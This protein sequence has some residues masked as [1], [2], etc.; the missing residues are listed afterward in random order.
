MLAGKTPKSPTTFSE[1]YTASD[2]FGDDAVRHTVRAGNKVVGHMLTSPEGDEMAV[3]NVEVRA[4][5]QGKGY[6]KMLYR[7]AAQHAAD[8]G[9]KSL[10]S[11]PVSINPAAQNVWESLRKTEPITKTLK[12]G[13]PSYKWDLTPAKPAVSSTGHGIDVLPD[14]T[15]SIVE[16]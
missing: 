16:N 4:A 14:W 7:Q 10:I 5:E 3:R 13:Q 15:R 6:A 2:L 1:T 12:N 11:D 8:G 9:Y